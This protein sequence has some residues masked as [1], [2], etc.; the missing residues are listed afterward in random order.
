M[1][2]RERLIQQISRIADSRNL[3][4]DNARYDEWRSKTGGVLDELFG[5][6]D[7]EQHPC[8]QRFFHTEYQHTSRPTVRTCKRFTGTSSIISR[9]FLLRG[10]GKTGSKGKLTMASGPWRCFR[11]KAPRCV[12]YQAS[13]QTRSSLNQ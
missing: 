12:V 1:S 5:H 7:S 8:V 2:I 6:L 10:H 4:F 11:P 13:Y 9:L 3:P